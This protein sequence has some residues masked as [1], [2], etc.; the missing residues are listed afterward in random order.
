ML[1]FRSALFS[2]V[3]YSGGA[4]AGALSILLWPFLPIATR[5][6]ILN[7]W[8]R[9]TIVWLRLCCGIRVKRVGEPRP[10]TFPCV[11]IANH[12]TAWETLYLPY[13]FSPI[14]TIIKKELLRIPFF[15]WGLAV[16]KPIAI[17]RN[18]PVK[19]LKQ[20]KEKSA[21]RLAEGN[22]VLI[23][24]QG[25]R[26]PPGEAAP[27]ARS[28]ADIAVNAGVPIIP[29]AHNSGECWPHKSFL[30]YPGT[31]TFVIGEPMATEGKSSKELIREIQDWTE[32]QLAQLPP[33]RQQ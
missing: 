17:D 14:S 21:Q 25:T 24:P 12:Q 27:Y 16:L 31:I 20:I 30:K 1:Y 19:A 15:G 32:A 22:N 9:F 29:V 28:G 8:H 6:R 7:N 2:L 11:I 3:F 4:L 10:D 23:F 33:G 18:S 13:L 26:I 5:W